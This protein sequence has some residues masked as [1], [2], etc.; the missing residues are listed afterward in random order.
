MGKYQK[1]IPRILIEGNEMPKAKETKEPKKASE[2]LKRTEKSKTKQ[3]F[4]STGSTLLD[5]AISNKYPGGAAAGKIIHI[6][7][8]NSTAKTVLCQEI[9]G[10]CQRSKGYAVMV[11]AEGTLDYDRAEL[12]GMEVGEWTDE[13][14]QADNKE[15]EEKSFNVSQKVSKS[16][17]DNIAKTLKD[18][19]NFCCFHTPSI[20]SLFNHVIETLV[21]ESGT[22][23][24]PNNIA[25]GVDSLSSLPSEVELE[26]E[27]TPSTYGMTRPKQF[28]VG[29]RKYIKSLSEKNICLVAIDQ[30]RDNVSGMGQN[31]KV[32][33]GKAILFYASTRVWLKNAK[34]IKN[35]HDQAIGVEIS[36][37]V[38]KNKVAPPFR[39]GKL[40]VLFDI[41]IDDVGANLDWLKEV[42]KTVE[43][44]L[45]VKG[46]WYQWEG[47]NI[48]Q[49]LDK[50][51]EYIEDRDMEQQIEEEVYRVWK[52]L[53]E[54][55]K[56]K[57]RHK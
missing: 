18:N 50:T 47:E 39:E 1:I 37:I 16:V 4:F 9:L 12:F 52:E 11:D 45:T 22:E 41:G 15:K 53:Y 21:A 17:R 14:Y 34:P 33:G 3:R 7:G 32:S 49:G 24:V 42:S 57:R 36:F 28:S 23:E 56:R 46:A 29:F 25:L 54:S 30:T 20:E 38:Q 26:S 55:P 43:S 35:K 10:A 6:Y 31:N 13:V 48:G 27:L 8:A 40:R 5:L 2:C 44:K 51:I 19:K